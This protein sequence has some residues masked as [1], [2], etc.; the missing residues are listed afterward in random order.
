MGNKD[1]GSYLS[2][3]KKEMECI[4]IKIKNG[5]FGFLEKNYDFLCKNKK[6]F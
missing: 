6:M 2:R 4:L 1:I 5:I 3:N